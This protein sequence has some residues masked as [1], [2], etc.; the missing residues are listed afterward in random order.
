[1]RLPLNLRLPSAVLEGM[2]DSLVMDQHTLELLEFDKVR[3]LLAGHAA[4]S[5]G[6]DLARQVAPRT[7]PAP[8]RWESAPDPGKIAGEWPPHCG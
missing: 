3:E 5:P 7:S 2:S 8:W 1:M 4:T 6:K